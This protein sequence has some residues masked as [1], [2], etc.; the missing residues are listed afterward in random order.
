MQKLTILI[1][2][3]SATANKQ[4]EENLFKDTLPTPLF[5]EVNQ[6]QEHILNPASCPTSKMLSTKY[7]MSLDHYKVL[8]EA[9]DSNV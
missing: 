1:I 6:G 3:R 8:K 7:L 4:E 2:E 5:L 9:L